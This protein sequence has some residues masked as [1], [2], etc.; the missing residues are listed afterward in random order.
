MYTNYD[1]KEKGPYSPILRLFIPLMTMYLTSTVPSAI[2]DL[3]QQ[4]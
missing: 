2:L 4:I 3:G 1:K